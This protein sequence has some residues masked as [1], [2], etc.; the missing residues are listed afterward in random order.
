M[1]YGE[2]KAGMPGGLVDRS[3]YSAVTRRNGADTGKMLFGLGVVQGEEPGTDI[4]LPATGATAAKFEGVTMY[5]ANVE[6]DDEG[7]VKL[8]KGGVL[9]VLQAGKVYVQ[10]ADDADPAYGKAVY[11]IISGDDALARVI[12]PH[13]IADAE[14]ALCNQ[15]VPVNAHTVSKALIFGVDFC[16]LLADEILVARPQFIDGGCITGFTLHNQR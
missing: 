7:K 12:P 9:D 13:C 10:V 6:M 14:P 2:P 16:H 15:V 3:N 4:A 1:N 5:S 8:P 11:L